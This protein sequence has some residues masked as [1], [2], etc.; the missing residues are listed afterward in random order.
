[1][2]VAGAGIFGA[3]EALDRLGAE[4]TTTALRAVP[5]P[6]EAVLPGK[7]ETSVERAGPTTSSKER[8]PLPPA[9][10]AALLLSLAA[11]LRTALASELAERQLAWLLTRPQRGPPSLRLAP[12]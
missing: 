2:L 1:M 8:L 5:A 4:S 11:A 3:S 6:V 12:T 9:M 7:L 10:V